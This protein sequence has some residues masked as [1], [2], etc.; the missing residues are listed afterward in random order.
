MFTY[1]KLGYVADYGEM[2]MDMADDTPVVSHM[3]RISPHEREWL[4]NEIARLL[5]LGVIEPSHSAH[6]SPVVLIKKEYWR[7]PTAC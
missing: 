1:K 2:R 4:A 7:I 5:D 6:V 3:Y